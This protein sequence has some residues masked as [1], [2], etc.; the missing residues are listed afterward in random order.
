MPGTQT[1]KARPELTITPFRHQQQIMQGPRVFPDIDWFILAGGYGC[2]KSFSIVL[3]IL[4]I[5]KR[6]I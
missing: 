6:L 3:C 5:V 4:D 2:G 1:N